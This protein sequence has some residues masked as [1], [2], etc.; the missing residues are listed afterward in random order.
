VLPAL[1]TLVH[2]R[3][4]SLARALLLSLGAFFASL[5][6]A[7]FPHIERLHGSPWQ[8][9]CLLCAVCGMAETARCLERRWSLRHAGVLILLYTNLV[10]LAMIAFIVFFE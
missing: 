3:R 10:I 5:L 4:P 1:L 9:A 7:G 2:L 8:V 6:L